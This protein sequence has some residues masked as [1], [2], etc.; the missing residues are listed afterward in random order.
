MTDNNDLEK[1]LDMW[2]SML[3]KLVEMTDTN[4]NK[5]TDD[6][7]SSD[8]YET[9]EPREIKN[10]DELNKAD[11]DKIKNQDRLANIVKTKEYA[12]EAG[13]IYGWGSAIIGFGRYFIGI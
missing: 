10:M 13:T 7:L 8:E 3:Q 9:I 1:R 2:E 4:N 11:Y 6:N 12:K 5:Q